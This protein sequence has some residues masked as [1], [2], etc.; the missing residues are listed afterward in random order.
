MGIDAYRILLGGKQ[1]SKIKKPL[2]SQTEKSSPSNS[3]DGIYHN[4]VAS[5]FALLVAIQIGAYTWMHDDI[6]ALKGDINALKGDINAL[7]GDINALN[8]KVYELTE[9]SYDMSHRVSD[10]NS[11]A[12]GGGYFYNNSSDRNIT[13]LYPIN[14]SGFNDTSPISG[15]AKIYNG[16]Y[17]YII[18]K[19]NNKYKVSMDCNTYINGQWEGAREYRIQ[20]RHNNESEFYEIFAIITDKIYPI[21]KCDLEIPR[22][23]ARSKSIYVGKNIFL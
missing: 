17:I 4:Y 3:R 18:S 15:I 14:G 11:P 21:G 10:R 1:M 22:H 7:K 5:G 19:M 12:Y 16:D 9:I 6:D 23:S 8:D 20:N 2:V 13:I